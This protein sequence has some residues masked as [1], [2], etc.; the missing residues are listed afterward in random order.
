MSTLVIESKDATAEMKSAATTG[1]IGAGASNVP[2]TVI[3]IAI[4]GIPPFPTNDIEQ[5]DRP[6][7]GTNWGRLPLS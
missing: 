2:P 3:S 4:G 6:L 1:E 5:C 7:H